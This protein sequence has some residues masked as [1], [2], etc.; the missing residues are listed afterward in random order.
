MFIESSLGKDQQIEI[1]EKSEKIF[2]SF[3]RQNAEDLCWCGS[4]W[5]QECN[6]ESILP[7]QPCYLWVISILKSFVNKPICGSLVIIC[8]LMICFYPD[9]SPSLQ[10]SPSCPVME[11]SQEYLLHS[12][13]HSPPLKHLTTDE[14]EH[15]FRGSEC[16]WMS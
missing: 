4:E 7:L 9:N 14:S 3:S 12:G 1:V 10:T 15:S 8:K 5:M 13:T 16:W 6:Q 11:Q 2:F